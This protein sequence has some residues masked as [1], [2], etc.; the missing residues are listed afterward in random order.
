M[1]YASIP[2]DLFRKNRNKLSVMLPPASLAILNAQDE[3]PRNGDQFFPFRQQSDLFYL[4]GIEQEKTRLLLCPSHPNPVFREILFILRPDEAL[5]I[6]EGKKLTPEAAKEISGIQEVRFN[7]Q[8]DGLLRECMIFAG[9]V[10]LNRNEYPKFYTPVTSADE[11]FTAALMAGFPLHRYSRLAPLLWQLRMIKDPVEVMLMQE[12]CRVTDVGFRKVMQRLKPGMSEYE[13]EA[14]LSYEFI[15]N[16]CTHA[17][18]P[19]I[20]GGA[21]ACSLHY[22]ANDQVLR[23][24]DL[25]LMDF[26][27]EYANYAADCSRTLP[28]NGRFT[29]RQRQVY[30]AVLRLQRH[31][32]TLL[33]PG[34]TINQVNAELNSLAEGEMINLGLF[35]DAELAAQDP[36]N[37]LRTRYLMHG[38][39][40][41]LGL[42][43]HDV[44]GKD[45]PLQPGMVLTFEPALYIREEGLG[46]RLEDNIVVG[47]PSWNLMSGIPIDPDEIEEMMR[48]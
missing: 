12:A 5:E 37:P 18:Q 22:H 33:V 30:E 10:Y 43:V 7:D 40:H 26:G 34:N 29:P 9:E 15:R 38:V 41:F 28:V 27:A 6:W 3:M 13:V 35:T 2:S 45:E 21:N 25:L 47:Y 31:A 1:R 24:G 36:A 4:T 19:I 32:L 8:W 16:G 23:D 44:G 48:T 42:D 11:R 17:Y 39:S 20:A 14:E 46:I